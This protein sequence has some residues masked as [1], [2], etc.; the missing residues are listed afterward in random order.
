MVGV[1]FRMLALIAYWLIVVGNRANAKHGFVTPSPMSNASLRRC[2][3]RC[4][5]CWPK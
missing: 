1:L 4:S 2:V 5:V 3:G